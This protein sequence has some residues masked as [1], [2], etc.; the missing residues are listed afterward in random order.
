MLKVFGP[1]KLRKFGDYVQGF[2][3]MVGEDFEDNLEKSKGDLEKS[4]LAW[5]T[6]L[7]VRF[8]R[9]NADDLKKISKFK[10]IEKECK[11]KGYNLL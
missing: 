8:A 2:Q 3:F 5:I 9:E 6:V 10:N 1:D 7:L 11:D 4:W